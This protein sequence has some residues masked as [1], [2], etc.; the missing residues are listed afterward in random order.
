MMS[1]GD[2]Y[3]DSSLLEAGVIDNVEPNDVAL[4]FLLQQTCSLGIC[5]D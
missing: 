1:A 5:W 2:T 3:S 4:L